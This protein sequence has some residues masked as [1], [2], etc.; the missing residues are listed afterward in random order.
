M[1]PIKYYAT[2][3]AKDQ[4]EERFGWE[5]SNAEKRMRD[6][7]QTAVYRG[8][9]G[10]ARYFD[11]ERSGVRMVLAKDKNVIITVYEIEPAVDDFVPIRAE[12]P[13]LSSAIAAAV[14][15]ELSKAGRE[16]K[17]QQRAIQS[18]VAALYA[19]LAE[20]LSKQARVYHP[21]TVERIQRKIDAINAAIYRKQAE[22][23]ECEADYKRIEADAQR[24]VGE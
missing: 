8:T 7:M 18:E 24:F 1:K 17:R 11:H 19:E 5:R 21:P 13:T 15:R 4:A 22:V 14:R 20:E 9:D 12:S 2:S 23:A 3:H 6:L 16:F 10:S